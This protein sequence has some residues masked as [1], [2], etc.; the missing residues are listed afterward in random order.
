MKIS[1]SI[2]IARNSFV[3]FSFYIFLY[4]NHEFF[5]HDIAFEKIEQFNSKDQLIVF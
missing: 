1:I 5:A 2:S 4:Q 3:G